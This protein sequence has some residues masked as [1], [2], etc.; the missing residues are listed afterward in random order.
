MAII[1]TWLEDT[2]SS[3]KVSWVRQPLQAISW[4]AKIH[5]CPHFSTSTFDSPVGN[6]E[7]LPSFQGNKTLP[8]VAY[9]E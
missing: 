6:K 8:C 2:H 7:Q 4:N 9:V 1:L 5:C 3:L